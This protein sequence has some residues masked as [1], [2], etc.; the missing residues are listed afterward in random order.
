[1]QFFRKKRL[2]ILLIGMIILVVLIGYSLKDRNEL[3]MPEK[4][5]N[6]TVGWAQ[7][8]IH[9][10][11][12]FVTNIFSNIDDLKKTYEEN[13]VLK[14]KLSNEK[15]LLYETQELKKENEELRKTLKKSDS[16]R[17]FT[18]IQATVISRSPE[19]W[20]E[21]VSINKGSM[22]GV[23]SNMAVITA[24]GMIGKIK[25]T[26]KSTST[27]QLLTGFDQFNRISAKVSRKKGKDIVGV[28]EEY[29]E[30]SKSLLFRIIDESDK[31]LKKGELVVSSGMGGVF[32]SGLPIGTV[33][34]VI[35]DQYGL[36]QTALI[37]P[38]ADMY[39][40]NNVII[41]D[42]DLANGDQGDEE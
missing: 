22:D 36:T 13:K 28:I 5:I 30:K 2:F 29:D 9:A 34:E 6:D 35:P 40:I 26:S 10:P 38:A 3:S 18:P 19:R 4:F 8:I 42:R 41:V 37:K 33:K 17:E 12:S 15:E 31:D 32:P 16:I 1:M 11:V 20:I 27:V 21:Q 24:D 14:E 7:S 25:S 39:Q 23:K